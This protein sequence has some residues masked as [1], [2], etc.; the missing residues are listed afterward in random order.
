VTRGAARGWSCSWRPAVGVAEVQVGEELG[1]QHQALALARVA[2]DVISNDLL[3]VAARVRI[4]GV[5]EVPAAFDI[6]AEVFAEGHG[7]EAERAD[8]QSRTTERDIVIERR[9]QP[10]GRKLIPRT[11][12]EQ[13]ANLNVV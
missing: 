2:A 4:G 9:G 13:R 11:P 7:A 8:P 3:G 6:A 1:G 5:D 12:L 10:P